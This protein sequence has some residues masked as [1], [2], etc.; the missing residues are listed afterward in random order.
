MGKESREPQPALYYAFV[1]RKGFLGIQRINTYGG[2]CLPHFIETDR[3][4][5]CLAVMIGRSGLLYYLYD[6][7]ALFCMRC[8]F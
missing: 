6:R 7:M 1:P 5:T 2:I 4:R 8:F 3:A